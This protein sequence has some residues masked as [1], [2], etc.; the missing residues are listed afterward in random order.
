VAEDRAA[1]LAGESVRASLNKPSQSS[2]DH[3]E[4]GDHTLSNRSLT[5]G[6]DPNHQGGTEAGPDHGKPGD[7]P[8]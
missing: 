8:V 5:G 1:G 6:T 3:V 2:P 4:A 7:V